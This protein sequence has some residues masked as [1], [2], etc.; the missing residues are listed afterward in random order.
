[1]DTD[2]TN[3]V[4]SFKITINDNMKIKDLQDKPRITLDK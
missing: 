1:M 4:G 2:S 3:K